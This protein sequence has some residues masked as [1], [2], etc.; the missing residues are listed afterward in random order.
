MTTPAIDELSELRARLLKEPRTRGLAACIPRLLGPLTERCP[1]TPVILTPERYHA[2]QV[3]LAV[4]L[5]EVLAEDAPRSLH[6]M[7]AL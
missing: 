1:T 2:E 4:L 6:T 3:S 7:T 5:L